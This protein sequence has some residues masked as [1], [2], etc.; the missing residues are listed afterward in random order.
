MTVLPDDSS[1]LVFSN[2]ALLIGWSLYHEHASGY[3][4][5]PCQGHGEGSFWVLLKPNTGGDYRFTDCEGYFKIKQWWWMI[6]VLTKLI[7]VMRIALMM[8]DKSPWQQ[9][10]SSWWKLIWFEGFVHYNRTNYYHSV[11]LDTDQ[12]AESAFAENN[13]KYELGNLVWTTIN[14][15]GSIFLVNSFCVFRG[16]GGSEVPT[17][18]FSDSQQR[19][20]ISCSWRQICRK[21][22]LFRCWHCCWYFKNIWNCQAQSCTFVDPSS[23]TSS[24]P[25]WCTEVVWDPVTLLTKMG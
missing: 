4:R 23:T 2:E 21:Q 20:S 24:W 9:Q 19:S 14:D 8:E 7:I 11:D 10:H 12:G 17:L 13:G 22:I 15:D 5:H 25:W 18:T 6:F 16:V 1:C 3:M